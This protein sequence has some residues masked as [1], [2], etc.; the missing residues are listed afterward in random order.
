MVKRKVVKIMK[1]EV[2]IS[3]QE[4]IEKKEIKEE[5]YEEIEKAINILIERKFQN[6]ETNCPE[7]RITIYDLQELISILR[8]EPI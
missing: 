5:V 6:T 2:E 3:R 7:K 8:W 1:I 4:A